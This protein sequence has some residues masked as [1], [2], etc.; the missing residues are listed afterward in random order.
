MQPR[1]DS[2]FLNSPI[3]GMSL[4]TEVGNRPWENPPDL[5][6]V[7]EALAFYAN[8]ILNARGIV[9]DNLLE[10]M[11]LGFPLRNY[12][13]ILQT[14]S[15]M[16]GKHTL[17]VGFLIAPAIEEMLIAVAELNDAKYTVSLEDEFE[18]TVVSSREARLATAEAMKAIKE[19]DRPP[20]EEAIPPTMPAGLM[21]RQPTK[22][23]MQPETEPDIGMENYG[24]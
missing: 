22:P 7:Q 19:M 21:A 6:T 1:P 13:N 9:L 11:E 20:A 3:P 8:K 17:D 4:T 24:I 5:V 2:V 23:M 15:V 12:A 18:K 14:A 10:I 16:E